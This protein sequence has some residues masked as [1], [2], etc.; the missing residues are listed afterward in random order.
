M[1]DGVKDSEAVI[2]GSTGGIDVKEDILIWVL[3]FE[4]QEL[5]HHTVRGFSRDRFTQ[6][7]DPFA[8][9]PR[10]DIKGPFATPRLFNHNRDHARQH[11]LKRFY[12]AAA[13]AAGGARVAWP[14]RPA[15]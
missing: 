10:I 1:L 13:T 8:Q 12:R 7:N 15:A 4:E 2:D 14:V 5:G 3:S 9:Q 6:K 11:R